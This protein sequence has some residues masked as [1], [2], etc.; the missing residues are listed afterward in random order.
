MQHENARAISSNVTRNQDQSLLLIDGMSVI[1]R[2]YEANDEKDP[3]Q[4]AAIAMRNAF[5]SLRNILEMRP[6]THALLAIDYGGETWR[7]R[8]YG[9]YKDNRPPTPPEL[10]AALPA[11]LERVKRELN[12]F[13]LAVPDV[14]ADDTIATCVRRWL[15]S[16]GTEVT[17]ITTDKDLTWLVAHGAKIW[18]YFE[19]SWRDQQWCLDKF[20]IYPDQVLDYLALIGDGTDGIPG[21][22]KCGPVTA[23]KWL[24]EYGNFQG[25]IDNADKITGKIGERLRADIELVKL[26]RRLTSLHS[27]VKC[28]IT[29]GQLKR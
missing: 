2:V 23:T 28:G 14:E 11:L 27:A 24:K 25:V 22:H 10:R 8:L 20:G 12:L 21:L 26:C 4:K 18:N 13:S 7:H 19:K 17:I 16:G 29:W 5:S 3:T 1:R 15:E 9:P 6:H